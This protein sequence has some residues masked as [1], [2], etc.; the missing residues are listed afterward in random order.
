MPRPCPP[1]HLKAAALPEASVVLA[2]V[3]HA[4]AN[5][6]KTLPYTPLPTQPVPT[7]P[8]NYHDPADD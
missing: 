6:A 3:L 2:G 5:R 4:A 1:Y 8:F 7:N